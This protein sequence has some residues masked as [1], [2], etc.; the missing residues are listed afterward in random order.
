MSEKQI[1]I[2]FKLKILLKYNT[3]DCK[4][5]LNILFLFLNMEVCF[6]RTIYEFSS[7]KP[8]AVM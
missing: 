1:Q 4:F 5:K 3:V 8:S 6:R 2:R 7:R